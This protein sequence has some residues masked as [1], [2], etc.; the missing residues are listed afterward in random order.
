MS[1][2]GPNDNLVLIGMPGAG[3]ST[4]G[5]LLAKRLGFDF[6]DT[7]LAIQTQEGRT[8]QDIIDTDGPAALRA[9]EERVLSN[10]EPTR[11]VIATGGSAV[12]SDPA[13]SR[14]KRGGLVINLFCPLTV[15]EQ[16]VSNQDTRGLV[17]K[18]GQ[19]LTD[20]YRE[21]VPLYARYADIT[22]DMDDDRPDQVVERVIQAIGD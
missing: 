20:L 10:L 11:C 8:L 16:R 14:L 7:D 12:Y 15:I 3:K 18:P 9:I 1:R 2:L 17:R 4:I 13:M 22:I 19:T 6:L 21:R 5:V